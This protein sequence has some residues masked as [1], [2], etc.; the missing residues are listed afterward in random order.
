MMQGASGCGS[1]PIIIVS[2]GSAGRAGRFREQRKHS[3]AILRI[4]KGPQ[5]FFDSLRV[6]EFHPQTP[7]RGVP[8]RAPFYWLGKTQITLGRLRLYH[9]ADQPVLF[10]PGEADELVQRRALGE[11][12]VE[13]QDEQGELVLGVQPA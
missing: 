9:R 12:A 1:P 13:A 2:S 7:A 6:W 3:A 5:T 4:E 8:P 11:E 10:L